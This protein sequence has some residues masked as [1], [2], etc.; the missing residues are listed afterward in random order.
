MRKIWMWGGP[1]PKPLQNRVVP[2]T[3]YLEG[4]ERLTAHLD[5]DPLRAARTSHVAKI[6][7]V[8]VLEQ[9]HAFVGHQRVGGLCFGPASTNRKDVR[10]AKLK[11]G[12][13]GGWMK[14]KA[15]EKRVRADSVTQKPKDMAATHLHKDPMLASV[16]GPTIPIEKNPLSSSGCCCWVASDA[17]APSSSTLNNFTSIRGRR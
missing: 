15:E 7:P 5:R 12:P 10:G 13:A 11:S 2:A 6:G 1:G 16:L 4:F 14:H 3:D 9:R 8:L 17:A